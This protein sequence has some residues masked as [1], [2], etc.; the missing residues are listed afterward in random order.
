MK[1]CLRC[2][3]K[4]ND[5]TI[6]ICD[7]CGFDFEEHRR[8]SILLS[9]KKSPTVNGVKSDVYDYPILT[10]IMGLLALV[11]PVFVFSFIALY[12]AKRPCKPS[13]QPFV[14]LGKVFGILG[15]VVSFIAITYIVF[16]LLNP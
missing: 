13:L 11:I 7:E 4:H 5:D 15:F 3:K 12:L 8:M 6:E 14:N 10:F 1:K 9:E 16:V 2:G